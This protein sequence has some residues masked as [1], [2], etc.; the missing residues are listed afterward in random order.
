MSGYQHT[1]RHI[2]EAQ[3]MFETRKKKKREKMTGRGRE[4]GDKVGICER[5]ETQ[6]DRKL[7]VNSPLPVT[8]FTS[9]SN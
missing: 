2:T 7:R 1:A 8:D 4:E 6:A 9:T 5:M 3:Q